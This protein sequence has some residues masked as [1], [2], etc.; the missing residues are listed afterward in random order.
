MTPLL[1]AE[2]QA[3]ETAPRDGTKVDLCWMDD[4]EVQESYGPMHWSD[5]SRNPLVQDGAGIW[6]MVDGS[7][8]VIFTWTEAD[9]R[10][11]P[12]HWRPHYG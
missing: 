6:V 8:K 10:G 12:T 2:W 4:G 7:G 5:T 3:M 9:P 11:A 1:D